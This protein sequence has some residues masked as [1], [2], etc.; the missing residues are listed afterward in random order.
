MTTGTT[1]IPPSKTEDIVP[2]I[3]EVEAK[4]SEK[5]TC[6]LRLEEPSPVVTPKTWVVILTLSFGYGVCFWPV[7]VLSAI[8]NDLAESFGE[9][10]KAAWFVPA[11]T[12]AD[13]VCFMICGANTDLLGRRWF[14]VGGNIFCFIG[15]LCIATAKG[16]NAVIAG[17]VIT[18]FGAGNCQMACFA[19]PELL[20]NKWRHIGIVL[21]DLSIFV[22][23]TIAP[24]TARYGWVQH[25]WQWNFYPAAIAQ[26]L[27]FVALYLLYFPPAHP[28]NI[29]PRQLV[30]ELD[31]L[32]IGLFTAGSVPLLAGLVYTTI[33]PS[34]NAHVIATLCVCFFF[35]ILFALWETYGSARHPLTPTYMF[36]SSWGRD[37]T[38]PCIALAVIN[39]TYFCSS[40]VWPTMINVFYTNNGADWRYAS[41]L[42]IVQGLGI[43]TGGTLLTIFGRRIRHWQWQLTGVTTIMIIFGALLA[44]GK[45][46][47]KGVM[48][49]FTFLCQAA[50]AW[51]AYLAMAVCQMGVDHRDL[52]HSGGISS[53]ARQ[54]GGTIATAVYTTILSNTVNKYIHRYVPAA[55]E[56]AGLPASQVKVLLGRLGTQE[57][58]NSYPPA[59][60]LAAQRA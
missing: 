31:Y 6:S 45:P 26:G 40:I 23:V 57:L 35:I 37:L 10:S 49:A 47:N 24:I 9:P 36:V 39:M 44:L 25:T 1:D 33:Y 11:W 29:D 2:S 30:K 41:V 7:P 4:D 22:A 15:H 21:A 18:G 16:S 19:L 58:V 8:G 20:P 27:A 34:D 28:Y 46:S 3:H 51:A 52:S 43:T 48:I 59:V 56:A 13:T 38:A 17:M 32:G 50:Y 53:V 60:A 42:S 54:G 14:L 12:L 5:Q 55:V